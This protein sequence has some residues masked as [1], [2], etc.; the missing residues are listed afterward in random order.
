MGG[1]ELFEDG[2]L[3][4]LLHIYLLCKWEVV[5]AQFLYLLLA[6]EAGPWKEK[7]FPRSCR[8]CWN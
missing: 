4:K 6:A 5:D 3:G 8:F 7:R 2:E 1:A